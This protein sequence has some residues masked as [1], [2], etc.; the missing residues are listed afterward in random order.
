PD[1]V[2]HQPAVDHTARV[3]AFAAF[4]EAAER[5][6]LDNLAAEQY[7]RQAKAAAD[8]AAIAEQL[9]DLLG[10]GVGGHVEILGRHAQQQVAHGAPDQARAVTRL[11]QAVQHAQ[12]TLADVLARNGMAVARNHARFRRGVDGPWFAV[13]ASCILW[14]D[15]CPHGHCRA[16]QFRYTTAPHRY[17]LPSSSG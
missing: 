2:A 4:A 1:I 3:V 12:G 13:Q 11:V 7:V 9:P 5:G 10:R 8:Q 14:F 16:R 15:S 17:T 6:H